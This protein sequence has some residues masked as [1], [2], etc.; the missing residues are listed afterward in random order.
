MV[1]WSSGIPQPRSLENTRVSF[2]WKNAHGSRT[3]I[4][5][6]E[7]IRRFRSTYFL[8]NWHVAE[9]DSNQIRD[10]KRIIPSRHAVDDTSEN[11]GRYLRE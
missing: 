6:V 7:F 2:D 1:A 8:P 3:K 9:L 4:R 11:T 5:P 10:R